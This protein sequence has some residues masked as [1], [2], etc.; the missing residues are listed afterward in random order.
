MIDIAGNLDRI[1]DQIGNAAVKAG[2]KPEDIQ[3]LA[4]SKRIPVDRILSAIKWGQTCFGE[5]RQQGSEEKLATLREASGEKF[6]TLEWH[7]IG[8]LQSNKARKVLELFDVV[9]SLD[10]EKLIRRVDRIAGE[11]GR[12]V[13]T[14][15]QVNVSGTVT[16]GGIAPHLIRKHVEVIAGCPNVSLDGFMAIGPITE[17]EYLIRRAFERVRLEAERLEDLKTDNITLDTLSMGMS[18]D[19]EYAILEGSTMVRLGTA[20]FGPRDN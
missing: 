10:S 3:L 16:Q 1:R 9:Q 2:R 15:L 8:Q 13:R 11:R 5:N 14:L 7:F 4:V 12:K 18:G 20:I 19:F 6:D 17:D